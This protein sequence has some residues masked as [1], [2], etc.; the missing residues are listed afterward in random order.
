MTDPI[1]E[2]RPAQEQSRSF[3]G[4]APQPYASVPPAPPAWGAVPLVVPQPPSASGPLTAGAI[5]GTLA[6]GALGF[7]LAWGLVSAGLE[8][9]G[10]D[11]SDVDGGRLMSAL[12]LFAVIGAFAGVI[13]GLVV[14][15]VV[16]TNRKSRFQAQFG[17]QQL[18]HAGQASGAYQFMPAQQ[19]APTDPREP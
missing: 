16:A 7:L 5:I 17:Q 10:N 6:G 4:V 15:G 12:M 13:I 14:G 9:N 2:Q 3:P 11:F 8:E 1:H 19:V 18:W